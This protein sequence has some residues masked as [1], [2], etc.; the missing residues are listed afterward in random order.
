MKEKI[1]NR[2]EGSKNFLTFIPAKV[3]FAVHFNEVLKVDLPVD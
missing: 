2:V 1:K 3:F